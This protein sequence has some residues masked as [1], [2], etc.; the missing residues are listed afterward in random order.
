VTKTAFL[1][2]GLGLVNGFETTTSNVCACLLE[3]ENFLS[4]LKQSCGVSTALSFPWH[5]SLRDT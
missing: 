1:I 4:R 3:A 2:H 5:G